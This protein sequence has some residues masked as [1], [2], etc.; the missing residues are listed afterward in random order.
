MKKNVCVKVQ[1]VFFFFFAFMFL[2]TYSLLMRKDLINTPQPF[3]SAGYADL[4][5]SFVQNGHFS[6]ENF[7]FAERGYFFPLMLFL[8]RTLL[9]FVTENASVFI[10]NI[11]ILIMN[12]AS[13][14]I[15]LLWVIPKVTFPCKPN[16]S[17]LNRSKPFIILLAFV[18]LFLY[19]WSDLLFY[20][21][22]D[23][24]AFWFLAISLFF[25][26]KCRLSQAR[27][28]YLLCLLSG[29]FAYSVYNMRPNLSFSILAFFLWMLIC[30][31]RNP[32]RF[33]PYAFMVLI[34]MGIVALPQAIINHIHLGVFSPMVVMDNY[35]DQGVALYYLN[36]GLTMNRYETYIGDPFIL[37]R[38]EMTF[39]NNFMIRLLETDGITSFSSFS[40]YFFFVL[41]HPLECLVVYV[42]HFIN[43][44]TPIFRRIYVDNFYCFK[45]PHLLLNFLIFAVSFADWILRTKDGLQPIKKAHDSGL[46][47]PV[48][49]QIISVIPTI[50]GKVETRY[51]LCIYIFAY[52]YVCRY[53]DYR[54]IWQF[55]RQHPWLTASLLVSTLCMYFT[56]LTTTFASFEG[57]LM[58]L[59]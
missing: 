38:A 42:Q 19:Y 48:V 45:I 47:L 34:G 49:I 1:N 6:L 13:I 50:V 14:A 54:R 8:V 53:A 7:P 5:E 26:E 24:Y 33:I 17:L 23:F 2:F 52:L 20:A 36:N 3:D 4:S 16:A 32:K 28:P 59:L 40:D 55:V 25:W 10:V 35:A 22:T 56:I 31:I 51:A 46:L 12:C 9:F 21:L 15:F 41:Q 37:T 29:V 39:A 57:P 43:L 11:S 44:L 18:F 27:H 30:A 58:R